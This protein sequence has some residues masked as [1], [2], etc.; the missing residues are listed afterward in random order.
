LTL[1]WLIVYAFAC[2]GAN[3]DVAIGLPG[4]GEWNSLG[5]LLAYTVAV[6]LLWAA[7]GSSTS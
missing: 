2:I 6:D 1:V 3:P 7:W 5:V 4:A